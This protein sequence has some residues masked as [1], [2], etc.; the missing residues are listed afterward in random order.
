MKKLCIL[1]LVISIA[2]GVFCQ[3]PQKFSYQAVIRNASGVLV[4]NHAIGL[5]ISILVGS[6]TGTAVYAETHTPTTNANGLVTIEIGGGSVVTGSFT[7]INWSGGIYFIKTETDPAGGTSY[8]ITGTSQ[9]LSVPYALYSKNTESVADNSITSAKIADGSITASDIASNAVTTDKLNAGA[10]TGVKIAQAGANSG[11]VLKWDGST[12]KP[13]NDSEGAGFTLPYSGSSS[14]SSY[15]FSISNNNSSA[16]LGYAMS[17]TPGSYG[18]YGRN[19]APGGKAIWG[20][21][22]ANSGN[23]VGAGGGTESPTGMGVQGI[24]AG[25]SGI[26]FGVYGLSYSQDGRGVYGYVNNTT[27]T[28]YGIYG[29]TKS[30]A[31][32][33]GYFKGGKF[34]VEGNAGIGTDIP[35]AKLDVNGQIKITGGSPGAGKVLTSDAAGLASWVNAPATYPS[36]SSG[37]I[38]FNNSGVFG[39]DDKL[40]WDNT[41]KRLG[42]GTSSPARELSIHG[43][44]FQATIGFINNLTGTTWYDGLAV[45]IG[46][47][48]DGWTSQIWCYENWPFIIGTNNAWKMMIMPNG[49]VGIG[50]YQPTYKLDVVGDRIRLSD[51]GNENEWITMRTDG[52]SGFLDLSF[53]GGKLVISGTNAGE[54][55]LLNPA[56]N[57][58]I[59]VRTW[60]PQY[61]LDVTG[62]I[63]AT[64]S[65]FYGGTAGTASGTAYTKPDYVFEENY[66]RLSTEEIDEYL[67]REN[68]LPWI[69]SAD[70]E[71]EENGD[72][73]NMTRMAFETLESV[74]NIQLQLIE[75]QKLIIEL[76]TENNWLKARLEAI[77]SLLK[78]E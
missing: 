42:L 30:P 3:P 21:A 17:T 47:T 18:I 14:H 61:E 31:G 28:N 19:D 12:W 48:N 69:T 46:H 5:R 34:Y 26:N 51:P 24:A 39:G 27:G 23:S 29:E 16:I 2:I 11:Q 15:A 53:S 74:E 66:D 72:A 43:G 56:T 52:S 37:N 9:I 60:N 32:F 59:G 70:K 25:N 67:E 78:A 58:W 76:K 45:G 65:V 33:S 54:N 36:G 68:H 71:K 44:D 55:I 57:G 73:V 77:E 75:Q 62:N 38:Q 41:S 6:S 35:G 4:T 1:L 49:N 7:G 8:S 50:K 64:G 40:F 10:V 22:Y 63:R 20:Y 13:G